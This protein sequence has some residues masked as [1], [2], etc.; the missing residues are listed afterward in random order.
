MS[1][2]AK[3]VGRLCRRGANLQDVFSVTTSGVD[4]PGTHGQDQHPRG[5]IYDLFSI[6]EKYEYLMAEARQSKAEQPKAGQGRRSRGE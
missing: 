5:L 6:N 1:I 4:F 2:L 3:I